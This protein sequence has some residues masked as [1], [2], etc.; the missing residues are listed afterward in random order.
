MNKYYDN[1]DQLDFRAE[2]CDCLPE[3]DKF[4]LVTSESSF[5]T[6]GGGQDKDQG[7]LNG[8][9][10]YDVKLQDGRYYHLID[11]ALTGVAEGK[12]N[13]QK[14]IRNVQV[15]TAQHLISAWLA[16]HYKLETVSHHVSSDDNDIVFK[17][18]NNAVDVAELQ[19]AL[20]EYLRQDLPVNIE[21][22]KA[23]QLAFPVKAE[24]LDH[25]ELRVI[26]IGEL[27]YNFCGC[28]HV[29]RLS[30]I[31]LIFIKEWEK[32]KNGGL[33][34]YLAGW[35]ILDYLQP[36]Y[37]QLNLLTKK[38]ALEHLELAGGVE[39]LQQDNKDLH[40]QVGQLRQN[41]LISL[42]EKYLDTGNPIFI[43]LSETEVKE[44]QFLVSYLRNRGFDQ[45]IGL[46]LKLGGEQMHVLL[47]AEK[48]QPY[49]EK[50]VAAFNLKGGGSKLTYQGGGQYD[51]LVLQWLQNNIGKE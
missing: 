15:H 7:L 26:R 24:K 30:E 50:L 48:A 20:N 25:E 21:Y 10:V 5:F 42:A 11:Q 49:W 8:L 45:P 44:G 39:K 3:G 18:E 37:N 1:Y 27:D 47:C 12:V 34:R 6:G 33:I 22:P 51:P 17:G 4:W 29:R 40:Y 36:R 16:N 32:T 46:V 19:E 43:E 14:R 2:I 31:G 35:Q 9:P 23:G 13:Y 28:I 41:N 38:L